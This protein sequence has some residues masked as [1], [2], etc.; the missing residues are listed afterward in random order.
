MLLQRGFEA[1]FP[2]LDHLPVG[3]HAAV[4]LAGLHAC[5]GKLDM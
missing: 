4:V 2:C 5:Y 3:L 1:G